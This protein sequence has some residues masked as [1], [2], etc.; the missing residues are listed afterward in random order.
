MKIAQIAPLYESV[1]PQLYGATE[2]VVSYLTEELVA[3]G[4]DVT[5]FDSTDSQTAARLI[6]SCRRALRLDGSCCDQTASH[7]AMLENVVER[8]AE[9]DI[10]H[11]HCDY[12]SFPFARR[13]SVPHLTTLH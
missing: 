10:L 8:A 13:S 2:S 4:H 9:F 6:P 12:L 1:P 5:L 11:F 3:L 7:F